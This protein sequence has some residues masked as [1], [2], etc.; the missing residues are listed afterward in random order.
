MT[1]RFNHY[2]KDTMLRFRRVGTAFVA[3]VYFLT[4]VMATHAVEKSLWEERRA[5]RD[6]APRIRFPVFARAGTATVGIQHF[7]RG[8]INLPAPVDLSKPRRAV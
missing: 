2:T 7:R 6:R 5:A 4:N 8:I 1:F 3:G